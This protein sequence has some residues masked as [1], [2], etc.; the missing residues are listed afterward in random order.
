MAKDYY[1]ILGVPKTASRDDIKKAYKRL[2]K[3]YHPDL[4]K[5]DGA[6]DKFKELNEAAAVLGDE[7]KRA[8]YD[9]YGTAEFPGGFQGGAGGFDFSGFGNEFDFGDI[10]ESFFGGGHFGGMRG[11]RRG[12]QRGADIRYDMEVTLEEAVAGVTKHITVPRFVSCSKC[13]GSGAKSKDAVQT[14]P[15]CRGSGAVTQ[16]RRTPFGLFQTTTTCRRC[17]GRGQY[18][19]ELCDV[20]DGSGR[21]EEEKRIKVEVPAGVD[22]GTTLRLSGSGEAGER[23]A[24]TGDLFIVV[25]VQPHKVFDRKDNDLFITVPVSFVG[26][27]LGDTIEVPVVGG[28]AK[29]KIPPGTQSNTFFKMKGKGVPFLNSSRVGDQFVKVVVHTPENLNSLQKKALS[30][31]AK[32]M[33]DKITPQKGFLDRVKEKFS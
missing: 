27:V 30:D 21:V 18:I 17:G 26:A 6:A 22:S 10:F 4:N 29:L 7:Q 3:K 8:H 2:A 31:F 20:C 14:C 1:D 23:G 15:D 28:E 19:S 12:P 13:D 16:T 33:G 9:Q 32:K 5:E 11:R 24:R 25:H